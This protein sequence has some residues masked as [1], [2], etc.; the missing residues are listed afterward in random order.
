MSKQAQMSQMSQMCQISQMCQLCNKKINSIY[1]SIYTCKCKNV[2]CSQHI[3]DHRCTYDYKS[4][5]ITSLKKQLIK[6]DFD[7][8]ER[9]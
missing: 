5:N 4:E 9:I 6:V 1:I 2:Y 8:L 3:Q 7:K